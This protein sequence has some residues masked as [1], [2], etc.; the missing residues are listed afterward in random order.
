MHT[1]YMTYCE[2]V[3]ETELFET[4]AG[5]CRGLKTDRKSLYSKRDQWCFSVK[6]SEGRTEAEYK[7]R[8]YVL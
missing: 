7:D 1:N 6:V 5:Q 4:G 3:T 8:E 2:L